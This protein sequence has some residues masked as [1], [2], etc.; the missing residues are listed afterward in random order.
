MKSILDE[1][2]LETVHW[3]EVHDPAI[4]EG[5]QC[6]EQELCAATGC[7]LVEMHV[8]KWAG[9]QREDPVLSTVLDWLKA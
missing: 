5:D 6:L 4:V 2:T 3:A 1:V 8:T 9:V 7:P